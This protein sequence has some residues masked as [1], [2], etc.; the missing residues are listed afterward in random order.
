MTLRVVK[1]LCAFAALVVL[2]GGLGAQERRV[3]SYVSLDFE[4]AADIL[5]EFEKKT[6]IKVEAAHD[7]EAN[8][9]IELT[10][11]I[12]AEGSS[13]RAD[14]FWNNECGQTLRLKEKGLL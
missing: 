10:N 9:T 11:R 4:Y 14:V 2:T 12:I 13:P 3:S 8:K 7:A 6:G 5:K 1:V